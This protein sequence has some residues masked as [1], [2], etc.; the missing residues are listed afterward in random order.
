MFNFHIAA[1]DSLKITIHIL[2]DISS[3]KLVTDF[4]ENQ[5]LVS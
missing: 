1:R 5:L 4:R 2:A 3:I